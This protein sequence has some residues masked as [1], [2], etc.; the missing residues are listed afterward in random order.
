VSCVEY[1]A[2]DLGEPRGLS[3]SA[4]QFPLEPN[5]L[6]LAAALLYAALLG[7]R[8]VRGLPWPWQRAASFF[9]GLAVAGFVLDSFIGVYDDV[10]FWDHMVQHVCLIMV[11]A[12]LLALGAP[13]ALGAPLAPPALRRF[14]ERVLASA[15]AKAAL[16]PLTA[17][18]I[19]AFVTVAFHLTGWYQA[20]LEDEAIHGLEHLAF[21]VAGYLFYRPV[22]GAEGAQASLGPAAR[23]LYLLLAVPVDVFV[24][25]ALMTT[26]REL[27]PYYLHHHLPGGPG[28]IEDLHLGGMV[29]WLGG[30]GLMMVAL[31]ALALKFFKDLIARE[32]SEVAALEEMA[33]DYIVDPER[34]L[35]GKA[36][37]APSRGPDGGG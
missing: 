32:E 30:D 4:T 15:P 16:S 2:S 34:P 23:L 31:A 29:M 21:L 27:F 7:A 36:P 8:R 25:V 13:F 20:A 22:I 6:I 26:T 35:V 5:A 1:L 19:Y 28:R 37:E 33:G 17:Y 10:L 24:G 9:V 14:G 11:A 3:L 12:P 18:G